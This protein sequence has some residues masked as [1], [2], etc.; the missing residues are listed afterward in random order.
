MKGGG[1]RVG[2]G[3]IGRK[4]MRRKSKEIQRAKGDEEGEKRMETEGKKGISSGLS[5]REGYRKGL[6]GEKN[7]IERT[8][9]TTIAGSKACRHWGNMRRDRSVYC[10]S[11]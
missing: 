7:G 5:E 1:E 3:R 2:Q 10:V 4:G 6:S 9:S 8:L 11:A